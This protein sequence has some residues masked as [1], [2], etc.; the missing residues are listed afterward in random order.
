[1]VA[2]CTDSSKVTDI[3]KQPQNYDIITDIIVNKQ[4]DRMLQDI[5]QKEQAGSKL[6]AQFCSSLNT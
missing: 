5:D 3:E 6:M 2:A 4:V 1:M